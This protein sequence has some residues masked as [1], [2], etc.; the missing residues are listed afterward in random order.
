M[1]PSWLA[2]PSLDLY[3]HQGGSWEA[4]DLDQGSGQG[5]ARL[6]VNPCLEGHQGQEPRQALGPCNRVDLDVTRHQG[7]GIECCS[8]DVN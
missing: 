8:L 1:S 7:Q 3:G 5:M 2:S 4:F 6:R